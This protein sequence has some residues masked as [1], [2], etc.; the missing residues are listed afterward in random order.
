MFK[1]VTKYNS[2]TDIKCP[3]RNRTMED[4]I[5]SDM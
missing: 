1:P 3:N 2:R 5:Y 4:K